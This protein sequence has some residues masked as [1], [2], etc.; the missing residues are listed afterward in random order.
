MEPVRENRFNQ[1]LVEML[2]S[3]MINIETAKVYPRFRDLYCVAT[4]GTEIQKKSNNR[5][6]LFSTKLG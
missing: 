1:F 5:Q 3:M 2:Q 4:K 6:N